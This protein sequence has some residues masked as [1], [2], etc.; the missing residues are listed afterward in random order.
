MSP[1]NLRPLLWANIRRLGAQGAVFDVSAVR[2]ALRFPVKRERVRDYLKAL[3]AGGYLAPVTAEDGGPGWQLLRDT[4][5]DAPRVREDGQE[6]VIG[7]GREQC[8]RAMRILGTFGVAELVA[9]ASTDR[10]A[11][12]P[13]EAADYCDRLARVGILRR[14]KA[15]GGDRSL[16]TLSP[17]RYTGPKPPQILRYKPAKDGQPA[18]PKGVYDPNTGALYWPDGRIETGERR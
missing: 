3:E 7:A 8:W 16:Y 12:A 4:G 11:I 5:V 18:R 2:G 10:W 6:I 14:Y 13:G 17:A 1:R 15:A 9:T